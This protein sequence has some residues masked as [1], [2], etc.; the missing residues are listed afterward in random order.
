MASRDSA[1]VTL[2]HAT[3]SADVLEPH[4]EHACLAPRSLDLP[5]TNLNQQ[6]GLSAVSFRTHALLGA[7]AVFG[8]VLAQ[9]SAV[10]H[11]ARVEYQA[12]YLRYQI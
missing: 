7:V 6:A 8:A 1:L 4:G 12:V 11:R 9:P 2:G 5:P 10:G 3:P